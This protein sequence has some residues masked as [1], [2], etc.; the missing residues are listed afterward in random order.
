MI[1]DR[2]NGGMKRAKAGTVIGMLTLVSVLLAGCNVNVNVR[3]ASEQSGD[4]AVEEEYFD[5]GV[6]TKCE[7]TGYERYAGGLEGYFLSE[8]DKIAV[9]SPSALPSRAQVDSTMEGLKKLGF[10]PVEGKY[11]CPET[12]TLDELIDDLEWALYAPE[13]RAIYCVRGGYGASEVLDTIALD[14]IKNAEKPIIGYS[15]IT[16]YHSAWTTQGLPSIHAC[17]SG[18]FGEFPADCFEAQIHM[19]KGEIPSYRCETDTPMIEGEATGILIGGNLSTFTATLNTEYDCTKTDEPYVLFIEEVG[20]NIQHIHRYLTI[21][22]HM[23]VLDRAQGIIF[24]EWTELPADGSGNF[25][26]VRGGEFESVADMIQREFLADMDIPVAFDFPAGHGDANYPL[27]MGENVHLSVS[28]GSYT[29][30]W[31]K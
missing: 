19:M 11:V 13:I 5:E 18:T 31:D 23:G 1:S 7:I 8:G 29:I 22:K 4:G 21:L 25:G 6:D 14:M 30:S 10:V 28:D 12:R 17:M 15:D 9:I 2:R 24:G 26:A 27:L 16:V 3:D 20:E